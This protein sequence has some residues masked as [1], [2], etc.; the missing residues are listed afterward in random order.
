[1]IKKCELKR[2]E[3]VKLVFQNIN[4]NIKQKSMSS[5][6]KIVVVLRNLIKRTAEKPTGSKK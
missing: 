5:M 1:M 4:Y 6:L 3:G 2:G